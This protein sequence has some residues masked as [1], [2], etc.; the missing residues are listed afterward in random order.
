MQ[1]Q[2]RSAPRSRNID[3]NSSPQIRWKPRCSSA[4][5]RARS[6]I[7]RFRKKKRATSSGLKWE[8]MFGRRSRLR[9]AANSI[10]AAVLERKGAGAIRYR[11]LS[12][13][14]ARDLIGA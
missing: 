10:E 3:K 7:G 2:C 5:A 9:L 12:E 1:T 14:E 4:R 13:K 11:S 8:N 6:V